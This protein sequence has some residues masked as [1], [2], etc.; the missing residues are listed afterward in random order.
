MTVVPKGA[1]PPC[2]SD[3]AFEAATTRVALLFQ[4]SGIPIPDEVAA[5]IAHDIVNTFLAH[6]ECAAHEE[7]HGQR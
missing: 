6:V 4:H 2:R 5:L 7:R 3:V 1:L